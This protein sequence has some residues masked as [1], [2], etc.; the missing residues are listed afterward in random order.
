[1]YTVC[2]ILD[3]LLE[4]GDFLLFSEGMKAFYEGDTGVD[5]DG[6]ILE[7][8]GYNLLTDRDLRRFSI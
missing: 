4:L 2:D 8:C 3:N 5:E 6:E 1:M 7:E